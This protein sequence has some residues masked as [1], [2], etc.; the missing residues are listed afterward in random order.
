MKEKQ[1]FLYSRFKV[2]TPFLFYKI[3]KCFLSVGMDC[4]LRDMK[5]I[6]SYVS[7][8]PSEKRR[9]FNCRVGTEK[10]NKNLSESL[11]GITFSGLQF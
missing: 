2:R 5:L 3:S 6:L 7:S 9:H 8:P 1:S 4:A 11:S 10:E